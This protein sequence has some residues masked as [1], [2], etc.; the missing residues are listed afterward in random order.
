MTEFD[1]NDLIDSI[2]QQRTDGA[3][4]SE[5]ETAYYEQQYSRIKEWNDEELREVYIRE[6]A[7]DL[8]DE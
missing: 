3:E 4:I 2:A 6:V 7:D 1:R 8:E 5:L